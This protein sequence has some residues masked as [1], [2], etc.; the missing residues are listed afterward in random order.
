M[1]ALSERVIEGAEHDS[2]L[3]D[4]PP[5]CHPGTRVQLHGKISAWFHNKEREKALLWL[6]GP[7]GV[8]KSAVVQTF[9]ESLAGPK[10]LGATLFFSKLNDRNDPQR[11]FITIAFQLATRIPAYRAYI[12]EQIA[13][14]PSLLKKGMKD[15]FRILIAEPFGSNGIGKGE[16]PWGVLLDGLDE[17]EGVD[18]Q[19]SIIWLVSEFVLKFPHAP[20]VWVITSRPEP[21]IVAT[22]AHEEVAPSHWSEYISINS[23]EACKDVERY[24][25]ARFKAMR[26]QYPHIPS[27]WPS[28]TQSL[29]LT[30]G[31]LGLFIFARTAARFMEDPNY[32]DPI[33]RLDLIL[34]VID[35]LDIKATDD[36]PFALLD[37]LYTHILTSI[38][39][40][41]RRTTIRILG[42]ILCSKS[43]PTFDGLSYTLKSHNLMAMSVIL[44]LGP[45]VVYSSL[46][47]LHSVLKI[48]DLQD[49]YE[50]QVSFFH[51]SFGD[52][53]TDPTRS[54]DLFFDR[55]E[56]VDDMTY[57]LYKLSADKP[58]D[59]KWTSYASQPSRE[60]ESHFY[61]KLKRDAEIGVYYAV[62]GELRS[63]RG[64]GPF[65]S[66]KD[67][68]ECLDVLGQINTAEPYRFYHC[69]DGFTDFL[70]RLWDVRKA[71]P[72]C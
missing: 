41:L 23:T 7:A 14:D 27:T 45:P 51:A 20:F 69:E 42:F 13:L 59:K 64:E 30:N 12:T 33:S 26:E 9:A 16:G 4:P 22:F 5:L 47:K 67:R 70:F 37:G 61:R 71:H 29:K 6:K 1:K 72:L 58:W 57:G 35:H 60:T 56:C 55:G 28:E 15:Q 34:S 52:Y 19:S 11:V 46:H 18:Q 38:P 44:S 48:P 63:D 25:N 53:L 68:S 32:A 8:G 62:T 24:L 50:N 54:K 21:H 39:S 17:C 66:Q 40:A 10:H 3:R 31:A 43:S 49:A 2:S 65:K 36:H